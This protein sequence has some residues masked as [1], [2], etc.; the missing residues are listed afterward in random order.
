MYHTNNVNESV[1]LRPTESSIAMV[2]N[3]ARFNEDLFRDYNSIASGVCQDR[4]TFSRRALTYQSDALDTFRGILEV[5][6]AAINL[7]SV[8]T[9]QVASV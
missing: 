7:V 4:F 1:R 5:V 3:S 6:C 2:P 8:S 9:W